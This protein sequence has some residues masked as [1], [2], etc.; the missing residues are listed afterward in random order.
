MPTT[1]IFVCSAQMISLYL[2]EISLIHGPEGETQNESVRYP[3]G[4]LRLVG[5]GMKEKWIWKNP[6]IINMKMIS[7]VQGEPVMLL[8]L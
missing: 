7:G 2:A 6:F 3:K 8:I 5:R 1:A 4:S